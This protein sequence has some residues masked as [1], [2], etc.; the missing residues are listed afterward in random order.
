MPAKKIKQ[1]LLRLR[2]IPASSQ[3]TVHSRFRRR[4]VCAGRIG[5]GR[6]CHHRT[7]SPTGGEQTGL[8]VEG[9]ENIVYLDDVTA[10]MAN[11]TRFSMSR[12]SIISSDLN[13]SD[14]R[15]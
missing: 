7:P 13:L 3:S 9:L 11:T 5:R 10:S 15:T 4:D 12:L 6:R 2:S 1:K 8:L 14:C